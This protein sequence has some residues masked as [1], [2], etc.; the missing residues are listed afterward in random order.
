LSMS[1]LAHEA[2][3]QLGQILAG[4]LLTITVGVVGLGVILA[5]FV[6]AFWRLRSKTSFKLSA[7]GFQWVQPGLFP[8]LTETRVKAEWADVRKVHV[9][10]GNKRLRIES[11][12]EPVSI[13]LASAIRSTEQVGWVHDTPVGGWNA[14]PLVADVMARVVA[15]KSVSSPPT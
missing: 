2:G 11:N 3:A 13:P 15:A 4:P 5:S 12:R 8:G 6:V 7:T 10:E 9:Q 1:G 14:H